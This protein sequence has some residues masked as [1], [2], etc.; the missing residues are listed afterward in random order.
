MNKYIFILFLLNFNLYADNAPASSV[1]DSS[2]AVSYNKDALTP[3]PWPI[4]T[5]TSSLTPS[6]TMEINPPTLTPLQEVNKN[7]DIAGDQVTPVVPD[8][9]SQNPIPSSS[10]TPPTST[11][12]SK[13]LEPIKANSPKINPS[14]LLSALSQTP[15]SADPMIGNFSGKEGTSPLSPSLPQNSTETNAKP[16]QET[17]IAAPASS[18]AYWPPVPAHCMD[19][20]RIGLLAI[21]KNAL[22]AAIPSK[23]KGKPVLENTLKTPVPQGQLALSQLKDLCNNKQGLNV[24]R[25]KKDLKK[26][27]YDVNILNKITS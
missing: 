1:S 12:S 4:S 23:P 22:S 18:G 11:L 26:H 9:S 3:S 2:H 20:T 21:Q 27:K 25:L 24:E 6:G 10:S 8:T 19:K 7:Y 16:V 13:D 14:S 5:N 17:L 15:V